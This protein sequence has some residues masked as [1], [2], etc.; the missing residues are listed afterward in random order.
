MLVPDS[1]VRLQLLDLPSQPPTPLAAIRLGSCGGCLGH[2]RRL[3]V[4]IGHQ[5]FAHLFPPRRLVLS[6]L[7]RGRAVLLRRARLLRLD[8]PETGK[9]PDHLAARLPRFG[10]SARLRLFLVVIG[11]TAPRRD[12]ERP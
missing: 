12:A 3:G 2:L 10:Q 4:A 9:E 7:L 1:Y 8:V 5:A 11:P 6:C